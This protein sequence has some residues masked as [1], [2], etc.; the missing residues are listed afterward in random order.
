MTEKPTKVGKTVNFP[1]H[2]KRPW[3][4][5]KNG[6]ILSVSAFRLHIKDVSGHRFASCLTVGDKKGVFNHEGED[7]Q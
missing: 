7:P 4:H 6:G 1:D 5:L 3:L 2:F